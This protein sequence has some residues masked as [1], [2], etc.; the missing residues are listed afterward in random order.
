[1][2]STKSTIDFHGLSLEIAR[3]H[4][5]GRSEQ[6]PAGYRV[7]VATVTN[8]QKWWA[9]RNERWPGDVPDDLI[10]FLNERCMGEIIEAQRVAG[11]VT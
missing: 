3:P 8:A 2:N 5:R 7:I 6:F 10:A 11:G 1:M 4:R 9:Y